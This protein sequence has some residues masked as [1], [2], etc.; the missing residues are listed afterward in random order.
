MHVFLA[1][2]GIELSILW[3]E[4]VLKILES[5]HDSIYS[6]AYGEDTKPKSI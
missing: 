4:R 1:V 5:F 3:E 2:V 6:F